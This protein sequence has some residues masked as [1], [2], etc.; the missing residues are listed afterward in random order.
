M[1]TY[2]S[3]KVGFI[4]SAEKVFDRISNLEGLGALLKNVPQE[5]IPADKKAMLEGIDITPESITIPGG[6]AGNITL[7]MA[8]KERPTLVRLEGVGTP[9]PVSLMLHI[10]PLTPETS[11]AYVEFDL[12]IPAMLKPMINGPMQQAVDQF[13]QVLRQIPMD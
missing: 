2:K 9:V 7:Q 3:D 13:A 8:Q 1:A 5:S 4:A 12:K 11:E 10:S 6:P